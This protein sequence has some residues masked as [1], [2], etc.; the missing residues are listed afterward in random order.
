[1]NSILPFCCYKYPL[2]FFIILTHTLIY[3]IAAHNQTHPKK[4]G[5]G[6]SVFGALFGFYDYIS[7]T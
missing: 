6:L 4:K 2:I 1:M 5:F 3:N 7:H